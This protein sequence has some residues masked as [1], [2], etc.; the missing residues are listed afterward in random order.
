MGDV[1]SLV[2]RAEKAYDRA[3]AEA[4]GRKLRKNEFDLEDFREQLRAVRRM[5]SVTELLG[6][7]PGMKKLFRGADLGDADQ[8]LRRVEA[9]INSMTAE[10]RRNVHILNAN[11]R[12]R[13]ALGSGTS[14]ADVNRLL[15]QFT[16][17]KKMLR[18]LGSGSLPMSGGLPRGMGPW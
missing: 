11:R 7:I 2:E 12:K 6:M 17:T 9:I 13:I 16:Q 18:K 5:G 3:Q 1:L 10:E 4:L 8:E 15:K 14:V